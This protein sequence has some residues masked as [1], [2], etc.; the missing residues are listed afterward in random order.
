M[1]N[2]AWVEVPNDDKS[3]MIDHLGGSPINMSMEDYHAANPHTTRFEYDG[4]PL[5]HTNFVFQ[6]EQTTSFTVQL[7]SANYTAGIIS[8]GHSPQRPK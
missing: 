5:Y 3:T 6:T 8:G 4:D 7:D 2:E 1:P